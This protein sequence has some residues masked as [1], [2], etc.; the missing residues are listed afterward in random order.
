MSSQ[1]ANAISNLVSYLT[2]AGIALW[3]LL[4]KQDNHNPVPVPIPVSALYD[5]EVDIDDDLR[6]LITD[7]ITTRNAKV[8]DWTLSLKDGAAFIIENDGLT[9]N[10]GLTISGKIGPLPTTLDVTKI[11][12]EDG[13]LVI[14]FS[15]GLIKVNLR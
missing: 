5:A 8:G 12:A 1:Q 2:L 15:T 7:L 3:L 11:K 14:H 13:C 10:G 6:R 4:H 9:I